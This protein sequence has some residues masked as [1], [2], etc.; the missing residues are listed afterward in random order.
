VYLHVIFCSDIQY[1]LLIYIIYRDIEADV[2]P[3]CGEGGGGRDAVSNRKAREILAQRFDS[4]LKPLFL[5]FQCIQ[6]FATV[7]GN[8]FFLYSTTRSRTYVIVTVFFS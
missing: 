2:L 4:S 5:F 1:V 8:F 7:L 3:R 6:N